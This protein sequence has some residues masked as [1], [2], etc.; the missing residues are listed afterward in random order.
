M[1]DRRYIYGIVSTDKPLNLGKVGIEGCEVYCVGVGGVGCLI[2]E[3]P[4]EEYVANRKNLADHARVLEGIVKKCSMLP[5]R[6]G[7]VAPSE[8]DIISFLKSRRKEIKRSFKKLSGKLEV[9]LEFLWKDMKSI[10]SD[11]AESNRTLK[12]LRSNHRQR[13]REDLIMAGELVSRILHERKERE[14]EKF[15]KRL[16]RYCDEYRITPSPIDEMILNASFLVD[17]RALSKFD[18]AVNKLADECDK[19]VHVRYIGPLAPCSFISL[20]M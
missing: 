18:E 16:R 10:F 19:T 8:R 5:M 4:Q 3:S 20:H 11:I 7:T 9:E 14:G 12:K 2:S 17:S 15:I 1:P 6:F 13:T